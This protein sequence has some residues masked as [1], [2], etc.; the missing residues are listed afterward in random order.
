MTTAAASPLSPP[1]GFPDP[2]RSTGNRRLLDA[3]V[4]GA[5]P[6][7][8]C[9]P[10]FDLP[11]PQTWSYGRVS[12]TAYAASEHTWTPDVVFGGYLCCLV[13][14]FAG[15]AM[16]TVLPDATSFLTHTITLEMHR[17][18]RTGPALVEARVIRL[19]TREATVTV[20]LGV[21]TGSGSGRPAGQATV[22]QVLRRRTG[23]SGHE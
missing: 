8:P 6:A 20:S 9:V 7:P 16:L 22:R 2:V 23:G 5:A 10:R 11:T 15:L 21:P 1:R 19:T 12:G 18:V 3:I 4:S 17:P 13:D 14:Q